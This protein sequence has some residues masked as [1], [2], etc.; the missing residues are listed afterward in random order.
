[1]VNNE[2][3][4]PIC[5]AGRLAEISQKNA[6]EYKGQNGLLDMRL[7]E[8]DACGSE[9]TT[10]AQSKFNK[11]AMTA[12]KKR[13]DGL[14]TGEQ[15]RTVRKKFGL[16]QVQAA[17][18]FGG[19]PVAFSKYENDDV[20]QSDAMD[21]LIRVADAVPE[22]FFFLANNAGLQV[23]PESKTI[24]QQGVEWV[25]ASFSV[26]YM[27]MGHRNQQIKVD[28]PVPESRYA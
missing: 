14:L 23:V 16:N 1:M 17:A 11:R 26:G 15:V 2:M 6:V 3:I 28:Y 8:C 7:S 18:V 20:M 24:Y 9:Q 21:R 25:T 5:E 22:A 10:A 13:V 19:G 12:F 4:C 27:S